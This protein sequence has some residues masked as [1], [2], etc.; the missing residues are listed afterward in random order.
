MTTTTN[1]TSPS[2][3][4][5]TENLGGTPDNRIHALATVLPEGPHREA[6]VE[7]L[8]AFNAVHGR[9]AVYGE[10]VEIEHSI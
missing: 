2:L 6:F 1:T 5:V 10:A 8:D 4:I 3:S 9:P 7:A